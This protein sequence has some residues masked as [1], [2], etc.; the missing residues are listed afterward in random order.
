MLRVVCLLAVSSFVSSQNLFFN[1]SL[2]V[3]TFDFN[4]AYKNL[5]LS[6]A[7]QSFLLFF[8]SFF[9]LIV[10][11][12]AYCGA[13]KMKSHTFKGPTTGFVVTYTFDDLKDTQGS[14]LFS[15]SSLSTF[16]SYFNII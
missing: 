1:E 8:F 3:T 10:L 12:V 5:W 7:G 16:S 2:T 4:E 13:S 6:A 9:V 14:T 11:F 15:L